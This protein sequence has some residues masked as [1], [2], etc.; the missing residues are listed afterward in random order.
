MFDICRRVKRVRCLVGNHCK[1]KSFNEETKVRR[2]LA[3]WMCKN[4]EFYD[5]RAFISPE[6]LVWA[7]RLLYS[8]GRLKMRKASSKALTLSLLMCQ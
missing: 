1:N 8:C 7:I 3:R 4:D 6:T 2:K 5:F